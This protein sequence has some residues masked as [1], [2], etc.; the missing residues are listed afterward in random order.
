MRNNKS[1]FN[2]ASAALR[3]GELPVRIT[4]QTQ[5]KQKQNSM[6]ILCNDEDVHCFNRKKHLTF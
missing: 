6:L 5:P 1:I 3:Y 2:G 4:T